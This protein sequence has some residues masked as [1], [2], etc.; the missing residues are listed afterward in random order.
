MSLQLTV[1]GE[2]WR[3]HLRRVADA[4]PGLV[5]V[6]KGNGY[7]FGL[8]RLA[9]KAEWLNGRLG[10]GARGRHLQE[11]PEV[12][13]RYAGDL[14]VLTPWRPF[15]DPGTLAAKHA[16]R[17]VHTVSRLEDLE[18]LLEQQPSARLVLERLTSHAA[19]R[20]DCRR[21]RRRSRESPRTRTPGSRAS[22]CTCR[23]Q[24]ARTSRRWSGCW[25]R[26]ARHRP[27][28]GEPPDRRRAAAAARGVTQ[29]SGCGRGSA[30]DLWLGDR[31]ALTVTSTVLDVHPLAKGEHVRL[32][33]PVGAEGGPPARGQ[34]RDGARHRPGVADERLRPPGPGGDRRARRPGRGR[35][36]AVAVLG[37]RRAAAVR[38]AAAHA[39][40]DAAPAE[41]R[42]GAVR[43][44]TWSTRGSATRR[45]RST[46]R[47]R[48]EAAA[49]SAVAWTGSSRGHQMSR[50]H[51]RAEVELG[52]DPDRD[53]QPSRSP[54]SSPP[55]A[56]RSPSRYHHTD[57]K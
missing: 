17:V 31:S 18:A 42:R 43:S 23:S 7:G 29:R 36:G 55:Q 8:G 45:R 46:G 35:P 51:H 1:D 56:A 6:A 32:P 11:L 10:R 40:L 48:P 28:L 22:R 38:R 37:R 24:R 21:P 26:P 54:A 33:R 34:R 16:H 39:G 27:G 53:G 12:A 25:P 5:P 57:A 2:R 4:Q 9:R 41:G 30:P 20:A 47:D 52:R 44:A 14:V 49:A 3:A 19:A 13:D 15:A 50:D